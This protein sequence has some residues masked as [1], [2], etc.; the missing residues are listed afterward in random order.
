MKIFLAGLL[1]AGTV[2]LASVV[3]AEL[4]FRTLLF[5]AAPFMK[6]FREPGLFAYFESDDYWKLYFLFGGK[7]KPPATPHPLLGWIGNFDRASYRHSDTPFLS[8]RRPVLLYGDSFAACAVAQKDC[9][10]GILNQDP[11]FSEK[12]FLLNYGV[13]G[14]GVDQVLLL[15]EHSIGEYQDP[16]VVVSLLTEDVDRGVLSVR[17]GQKPY[18]R[19]IDDR[20][21]LSGVP[22]D[23]RPEHFFRR[24]PP[25]IRS[26]LFRMFVYS[27]GRPFKL[28][29]WLRP[30]PAEVRSHIETINERILRDLVK[31]LR[32]RNVDHVF[33][34]FHPLWTLASQGDWRDAFLRR[35][36][37][38]MKVP[39]L[40]S[41]IIV[42]QHAARHGTRLEDYY[43]EDNGHPNAY[44]NRI[45]A[46]ELKAYVMSRPSGPRRSATASSISTQ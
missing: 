37:E 22:I 33:V 25:D 20:L 4:T 13:G 17:T 26:Y 31:D 44:Q 34:I 40:S 7:Y 9:F 28:K 15:Y 24:H 39:Y 42:R 11:S 6:R 38:S 41:K 3:V 43:L 2:G 29:R 36:F 35:L 27:D 10:Q 23:S 1:L 12:H 32:T 18:Y 14:Y 46:D 30:R 5:S 45:I 8:R 21:V 16:F 19:V